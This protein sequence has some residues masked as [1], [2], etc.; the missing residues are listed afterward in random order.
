VDATLKRAALFLD[1][2][3][4]FAVATGLRRRGFDVLT[5]P[6]AGR[7]R[8]DDESQLR[9]AAGQQRAI[10]TLNRGDFARLHGEM[11][12]GGEHHHGIIV[13]RQAA[14]GRVVRALAAVLGTRDPS[15]FRDRLIWLSP[16]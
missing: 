14:A 16:S 5:T 15:E 13:S 11:L 8:E 2:D 7:R 6:E 1:E 4:A 3:V 10:F 9:F 12:A